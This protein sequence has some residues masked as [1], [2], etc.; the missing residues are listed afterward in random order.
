MYNNVYVHKNALSIKQLWF[1]IL[2]SPVQRGAVDE[3]VLI[4]LCGYEVL[5]GKIINNINGYM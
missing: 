5:I 2:M 4:I 3:I 1:V